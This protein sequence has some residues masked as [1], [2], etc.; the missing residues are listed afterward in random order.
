MIV[1]NLGSDN[2][3]YFLFLFSWI[4]TPIAPMAQRANPR[5]GFTA[6]IFEAA[7]TSFPIANTSVV[8]TYNF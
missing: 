8:I 3:Y 5:G 1:H 7:T 6:I 4:A 2:V